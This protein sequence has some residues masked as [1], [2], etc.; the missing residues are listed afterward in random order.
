M[1]LFINI[2]IKNNMKIIINVI[3]NIH[4]LKGIFEESFFNLKFRKNFYSSVSTLGAST[5][6]SSMNGVIKSSFKG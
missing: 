2:T 4:R 3:M 5:K 1:Y 6:E